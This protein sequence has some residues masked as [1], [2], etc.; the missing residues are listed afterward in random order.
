M[1]CL[2]AEAT[3]GV[4]GVAQALGA[5][6]FVFITGK[7]GV[8]KTTVAAALALA[9]AR[10]GK[11]VLIAMCNTKE[12]LSTLLG[13]ASV[14]HRTTLVSES[15]WAV[16]ISPELA[17]REYGE[18]VLR[19]GSLARTV[20]DNKYT[21]AFFRATPGVYE[22]AILGKAWFHATEQLADGRT[23]FDV[24]ILDAPA[25]GHG[26]DML[27]VPR[28]IL[29][30]APSGILRRDA[31]KAWTMFQDPC[32]TAVL[33]VTLPEE[34]PTTETIELVAS[35]RGELALPLFAV[36]VN[37]LFE[38]IFSPEERS[39]LV[40]HGA[41]HGMDAPTMTVSSQRS[42]LVAGAF[43]AMREQTQAESVSR[44]NRAIDGRTVTLPFLFERAST[45]DGIRSLAGLL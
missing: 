23:R 40:A 44:L 1:S 21:K 7:G 14:G 22:W 42:A 9:L 15:V 2:T 36:F 41:P 17:L 16:N 6:R 45:L 24:V 37:G 35:V 39:L 30:V 8:G 25:T 27:R 43:R 20:F 26:M 28:V 34:M 33:V 10:E 31:E 18:T 5:R 13:S 29:D 32:R 4:S 3:S 38:P 19:I 12:R 11:R